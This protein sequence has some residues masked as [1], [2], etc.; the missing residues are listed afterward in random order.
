MDVLSSIQFYFGFW[1]FSTLQSPRPTVISESLH[2]TTRNRICFF[3][4]RLNKRL[5]TFVLLF[6]III[7]VSPH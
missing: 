5:H 3:H 2:H 4:F 1:E 6:K 7:S